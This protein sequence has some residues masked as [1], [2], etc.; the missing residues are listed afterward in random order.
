MSKLEELVY[1][2][3][4]AMDVATKKTGEVVESSKLRYQMKQIEWEIEKAYA[5]LG[6]IVYEAN[7]SE[8]SFEEIIQLAIS[9]ID[10]L[11][12][13]YED[14]SDK[15]RMHKNVVKC[16]GCGRDND[17]ADSFCGR[18]GSSLVSDEVQAEII[19]PEEEE[20]KQEDESF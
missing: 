20:E 7:K 10:D 11:K 19:V 16:P 17:L 13:H 5:K 18:C 3:K 15:L 1:L 8:D 12:E 4:D 2:A 14:C 6:A 9:E